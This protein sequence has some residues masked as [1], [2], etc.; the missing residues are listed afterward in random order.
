MKFF[1]VLLVLYGLNLIAQDLDEDISIVFEGHQAA[2]V[3]Y[4]CS[5]QIFIKHNPDRC[6]ERFLP[7]STYKIAN[8]LIG[9]ETGI[10]KDA[11]FVIP[12]DSIKTWN[13]NW[14]G[15]H[16]LRTAI[17][18]SVV[19]WYK[20]LAR[21]IGRDSS[22]H[23]LNI[24]DYGNKSIGEKEDNYW[25]DNSLKISADEQVAFIK[26]FYEYKLPVSNRSLDIVK[27][28]IIQD[29]TGNYVMRAKTG[30]GTKEDGTIIGWYVGYL[31]T[32]EN[33][34]LFALN[35]DGKSFQEIQPLRKDLTYSIFRR[36]S[37][38]D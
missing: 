8:S 17:K 1:T 34:Y 37:I 28:I 11:E 5:S 19:P 4:D 22:Q 38:I 29:S 30:A 21:K 25:L 23:Y 35:I 6:A 15:D 2:F 36:L 33:T 7:A 12:W 13:E 20:E 27:E 16:N 14:N 3:L 31:E 10:I 32:K 24:F 9:L 26:K 18:Y